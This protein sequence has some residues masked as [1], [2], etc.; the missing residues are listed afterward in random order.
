MSKRGSLSAR[1]TSNTTSATLSRVSYSDRS[2]RPSLALSISFG[3]I[4]WAGCDPKSATSDSSQTASTGHP[5]TKSATSGEGST[6]SSANKDTSGPQAKQA[7]SFEVLSH[8]SRGRGC[9]INKDGGNATAILTNSVPNGPKDY[10]Q[11]TFDELNV[12]REDQR[13]EIECELRL[14]LRWTPG[15]RIQSKGFEIDLSASAELLET[16]LEQENSPLPHLRTQI[17]FSNRPRRTETVRVKELSGESELGLVLGSAMSS[18]CSGE[19][20]WI[21]KLDLEVAKANDMDVAID[22][23]SVLSF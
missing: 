20:E 1:F 22:Q 13:S 17:S 10:A 7:P 19:G 8:S 12:P 23:A 9:I 15:Y 14:K 2:L 18:D 16:L 6:P 3:V 5:N 21:A 4:L 11:W